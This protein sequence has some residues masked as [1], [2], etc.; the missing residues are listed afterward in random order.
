MA[1]EKPPA[2]KRCRREGLKLF[3][4]GQRCYTDK[5]G[6]ERRNFPPGEHGRKRPKMTPYSLQL[7]EKQKARS[8]YGLMEGQFRNYYKKASRKT[9][10]TGENL[11]KL[12][13]MRLDNIVFKSGF[14]GSRKQSRQ[15]IKHNHFMVNGRKVNI[16]SFICRP[17]DIIAVREK[18]KNLQAIKD[19]IDMT[20][21][22]P[23]WLEADHDNMV[24]KILDFPD[25]EAIDA[26]IK[27]NLIV[28][29]YS[30]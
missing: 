2:C 17:N 4:K 22:V 19:A 25:R 28:E 8:Y 13:E 10:I 29:L 11:L 14:A 27:E 18:S 7:R 21:T 26:P 6:V 9:G 20:A 16:P 5:C 15:L 30:K 12:I 1:R 3:L 24:G 23:V